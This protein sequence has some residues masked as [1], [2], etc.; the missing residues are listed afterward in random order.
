MPNWLSGI[1]KPTACTVG[2][3]VIS[4]PWARGES[5]VSPECGG[6][7]TVT[8]KGGTADR[9]VSASSRLAERIEIHAIKVV[10]GD[11]KMRPLPDGLRIPADATLTLKPR[12]YHLLM[13]GLKVPLAKGASLPVTLAFDKAGSVEIELVIRAT[14]LVGK[15]IL[16]EEAQRG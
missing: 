1:R 8:N 9:L 15:E 6:F 5:Q 7:F 14:G 10:G 13:L 11:I 16:V 2:K 12:G 3:L 4:D